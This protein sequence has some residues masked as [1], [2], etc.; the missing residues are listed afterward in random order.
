MKTLNS[1]IVC[2]L[3]FNQSRMHMLGM[4]FVFLGIDMLVVKDLFIES[5]VEGLDIET[6]MW[7]TVA[8]VGPI[9]T[10]FLIKG[11][12]EETSAP[13]RS[14]IKKRGW[15]R[16][17]IGWF[18]WTMVNFEQS[19]TSSNCVQRHNY[20][21]MNYTSFLVPINYTACLLVPAFGIFKVGNGDL[22]G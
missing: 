4:C 2:V 8:A 12:Q 7:R 16:D 19:Y 13:E 18:T 14:M 5:A 11:T 1:H 21:F 15:N 6:I 9:T 10:G 22:R 17:R 3:I 20:Y